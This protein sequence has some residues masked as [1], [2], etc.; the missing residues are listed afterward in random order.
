M[1]PLAFTQLFRQIFFFFTR[2]NLNIRIG[3]KNRNLK[4][5]KTKQNK[6][7]RKQY[8]FVYQDPRMYL[9][10]TVIVQSY[11]SAENFRITG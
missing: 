6:T 11:I 2:F 3:Y 7:K 4:Q 8:H 9:I 1:T 5:N 10:D